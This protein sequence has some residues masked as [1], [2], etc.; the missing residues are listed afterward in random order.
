MKKFLILL[1]ILSSYAFANNID[2][3]HLTGE[4]KK[5]KNN[6]VMI[7]VESGSCKGLKE[8]KISPKIKSNI[9]KNTII[10]FQINSESCEKKDKNL[11]IIKIINKIQI[12]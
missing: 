9:E 10:T 1:L 11:E 4:V 6:H 12:K 7:F 3:L 2:Y 5:I 8:F